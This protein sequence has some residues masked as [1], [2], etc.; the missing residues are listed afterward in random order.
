MDLPLDQ[1]RPFYRAMKAFNAILY[2]Q[3]NLVQLKM[4]PGEMFALDNRRVLHGRSAF[5]ATGGT[6]HL[7]GGFLD[8]DE[9]YSRMRVLQAELGILE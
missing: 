7:Q 5:S 6:R 3:E 8:W 4:K 2:R 1:I 9:V